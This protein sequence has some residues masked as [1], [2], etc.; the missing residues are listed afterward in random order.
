M[1][2]VD[3]VYRSQRL[4]LV[5]TVQAAAAAA[6]A[7]GFHER[8]PVTEHV[9]ALV[10]AGQAHVVALV[11]AYLA[12]KTGQAIG[13]GHVKGLNADL[14]TVARLRGKPA[15]EVYDRPF[16][17]LGGQLAEGAPFEAALQSAQASVSR[18]VRTDLQLAQTH[19]ARD[20][21]ASDERI[22]GWRR[23]LSGEGCELCE[24]AST[25]TYRTQDLMP[26]HEHCSCGVEPVYGI[27]PVASVGTTVRVEDDPELGPR[28]VADSWSPTGPRLL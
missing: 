19:S 16:G 11:D 22:V 12:A 21:M 26:I 24:A 6:W 14:Y 4:R 7:Q 2:A 10:H 20:W 9:L 5:N 18:L 27:E 17:A 28:L 8:G 13:G 25:R 1:S 3:G 23:V 15:E